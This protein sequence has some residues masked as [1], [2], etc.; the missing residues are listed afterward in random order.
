[1]KYG[2]RGISKGCFLFKN[3]KIYRQ[4]KCN[5]GIQQLKSLR[6]EVQ[7]I[8][9]LLICIGKFQIRNIIATSRHRGIGL[10]AGFVFCKYI[11]PLKIIT[12]KMHR[13]AQPC[14]EKHIENKKCYF[15]K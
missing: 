6:L 10:T 5:L 9:N 3:N 1:M 11:D 2:W 15:D 7:N 14:V 12:T 13:I 8:R 4:F